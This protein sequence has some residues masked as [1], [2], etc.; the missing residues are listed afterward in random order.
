[1]RLLQFLLLGVTGT[2]FDQG[3][4][5]LRPLVWGYGGE[6][7]GWY[8]VDEYDIFFFLLKLFFRLATRAHTLLV[9]LFLLH[10]VGPFFF[11]CRRI[12]ADNVLSLPKLDRW[13][14]APVVRG[15]YLTFS[16][17][18]IKMIKRHD[19]PRKQIIVY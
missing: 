16:M 6:G 18:L 2:N 7:C 10:F 14:F 1:M 12:C 8:F 19:F 5:R 15:V 13:N 11:Q 3:A 9:C 17:E 4:R